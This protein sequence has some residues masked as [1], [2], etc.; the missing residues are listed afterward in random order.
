MMKEVFIYA[1]FAY[2]SNDEILKSL[3]D[4]KKI[5]ETAEKIGISVV[6]KN[7]KRSYTR[8]ESLSIRESTDEDNTIEIMLCTNSGGTIE[9]EINRLEK[10]IRIS[11]TNKE[12]ENRILAEMNKDVENIT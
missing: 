2:M 8:W 12:L 5:K 7:R 3:N 6:S 4:A 9:E 11:K 10:E 1:V